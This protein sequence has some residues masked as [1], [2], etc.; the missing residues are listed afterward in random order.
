MGD[1]RVVQKKDIKDPVHPEKAQ[2]KPDHAPKNRGDPIIE[3]D[4]LLLL[5]LIYLLYKESRDEEFLIMLIFLGFSI[6]FPAK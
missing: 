4:D 5:A 6:L 3:T 1:R 2:K